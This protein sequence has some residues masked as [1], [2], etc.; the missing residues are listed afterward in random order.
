MAFVLIGLMGSAQ[1]KAYFLSNTK[2]AELTLVDLDYQITEKGYLFAEDTVQIIVPAPEQP[3]KKVRPYFINSVP[4]TPAIIKKNADYPLISPS[5]IPT[6]TKRL[7]SVEVA[8]KWY[9]MLITMWNDGYVGGMPS[10][11]RQSIAV[12]ELGYIYT[13]TSYAQ[14]RSMI[15]ISHQ[16]PTKQELLIAVYQHIDRLYQEQ[17]RS[18]DLS[19]WGEIAQLIKEYRFEDYPAVLVDRWYD[20]Q[21][22]LSIVSSESKTINNDIHYTVTIKNDTEIG[23]MIPKDACISPSKAVLF[24]E[25]RVEDRYK[26]WDLLD[27]YSGRH[28][29]YLSSPQYIEPGGEVTFTWTLPIQRACGNCDG[30][31]YSGFQIY[32]QFHNVLD[33]YLTGKQEFKGQSYTVYPHRVI[34]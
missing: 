10:L 2:G 11:A 33:W 24:Y 4:P 19:L 15:M 12:D 30:V 22:H 28:Y 13:S 1:Q 27:T 21:E 14:A 32:R 8:G 6:E 9:R 20:A 5:G 3:I 18:L 26:D 29:K 23:Y 17:N 7:D 31:E 34:K 25:E 16:D